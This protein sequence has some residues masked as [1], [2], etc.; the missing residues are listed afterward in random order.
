MEA[1]L[2]IGQ[3]ALYGSSV[4]PGYDPIRITV[5]KRFAGRSAHCSTIWKQCWGPDDKNFKISKVGMQQSL[6]LKN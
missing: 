4:E 5:R 1:V 6:I 3:G 2:R